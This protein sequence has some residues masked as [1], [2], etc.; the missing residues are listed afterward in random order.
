MLSLEFVNEF[1]YRHFEGVIVSSNGTHFN[2]RCALCGDS[3]KNKR[4]KRFNLDYNNENP[5]W[6]CFNCGE[7][8]SF[9]ELYSRLEG[10][11]IDDAKKDL[12]SFNSD[13]LIQK[14]SYRKKEKVI[15]EIEYEN[16]NWILN[17]CI[18][19]H[20]S[21]DQK[22]N[23]M[24]FPEYLKILEDFYENR[25]IDKSFDIFIS[26]DGE[27][28]NR[29]I[30]PVYGKNKEI[31]YFQARRIPGSNIEPK[32]KNPTLTKGNIILNKDKFDKEKYIVV[33]EGILDA[34][35]IGNQGTCVFGSSISD[36]FI[37]EIMNFTNKGVIISLDND[38]AGYDSLK[39]FMFGYKKR[40][41]IKEKNKY[42]NRVKYFIYPNKYKDC[43][44]INRIRVIHNIN[45]MYEIILNN[46]YNYS[47]AVV[48]LK[49][50]GCIK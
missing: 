26:Y 5:I 23:F 2:A 43:K 15:K 28:K 9:L 34:Y 45:N 25:K 4:K 8:G 42:A 49:L 46:S 41:I 1:M 33:T 14:L 16:H 10:V 29:I 19:L 35:T 48:K 3:K 24:L 7:S 22:M 17:D 11:S 38:K 20:D 37:K 6:H 47:S 18:S 36:E 39:K 31:T 13:Y 27:Y 32:Y 44:D 50:S 12:Y 30:I 40:R 21:N